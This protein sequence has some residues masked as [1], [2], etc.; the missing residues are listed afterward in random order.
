MLGPLGVC[1]NWYWCCWWWWF[2]WCCCIVCLSGCSRASSLAS[3]LASSPAT[4]GFATF[5]FALGTIFRDAHGA[6]KHRS[7]TSFAKNVPAYDGA[8]AFLREND[9]GF[10]R[11][12]RGNSLVLIFFAEFIR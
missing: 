11:S 9:D 4:F 2:C 3:S 8:T 1:L 12:R 5:G 6:I 10:W 7:S